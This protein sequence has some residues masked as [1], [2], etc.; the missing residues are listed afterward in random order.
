MEAGSFA[1]WPV[2]GREAPEGGGIAEKR[3]VV[4]QKA[5]RALA[6]IALRARLFARERAMVAT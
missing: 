4:D 2:V 6:L 3:E 1:R 5:E